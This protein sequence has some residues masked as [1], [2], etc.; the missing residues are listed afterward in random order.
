MKKMCIA[1]VLVI[2][3]MIPLFADDVTE[4]DIMR[5][6]VKASADFIPKS[7]FGDH[8]VAMQSGELSLSIPLTKAQLHQ[9]E[10]VYL[11]QPLLN[12][13]GGVLHP[14]ISFFGG[15][16]L[17]EQG[18]VSLSALWIT[19]SRNFYALTAG[20]NL[21]E[22]VRSASRIKPTPYAVFMGGCRIADSLI[23]IYGAGISYNSEM[24]RVNFPVFPLLGLRWKISETVSM[25]MILPFNV[26]VRIKAG[27]GFK[28]TCY[29]NGMSKVFRMYNEND[30]IWFF[31]RNE[32]VTVK[33]SALTT[34]VKLDYHFDEHFFLSGNVGLLAGRKFSVWEGKD[35]IF[36]DNVK[37][38]LYCKV[39]V[40]YQFGD[41]ER[42]LDREE[43][44]PVQ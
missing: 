39:S 36:Q 22:E 4:L 6:A 8:E 34:G 41:R 30:S 20:V 14:D 32:I 38:S 37:S 26:S 15:T 40:G 27:T 12:I 33:M 11:F 9:G 31:G 43:E 16:H 23:L 35:R 21:S 24:Y 2:A 10:S 5:P 42:L 25:S 1:F 17:V 29:L 13:R 44:T 28:I 3:G 18:G 19:A 7:R